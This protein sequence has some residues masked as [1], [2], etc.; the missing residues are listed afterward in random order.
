MAVSGHN[1][2]NETKIGFSNS[3]G[4]SIYDEK[5]NEIEISNLKSPID[6]IIQRD[7]NLPQ[8]PYQFV[9]ATQIQFSYGN[10]L[11]PSGIH[12]ASQNSSLH[13]ELKPINFTLGYLITIK[14]GQTPIVNRKTVD[15]T[16]FKIFC[17]CNYSF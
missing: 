16:S 4:L 15:F 5:L 12:L 3:I 1:G 2:N 14:L 9:N 13:I 10:F 11:L 17:P 8:F 6:L 7:S